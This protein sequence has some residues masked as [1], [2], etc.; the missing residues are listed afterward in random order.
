MNVSGRFRGFLERLLSTR[1]SEAAHDVATDSELLRRFAERDDQ[2]AFELLVW[3]HGMMVLGLCE[4]QIRDK[5]LAEDAFQAIFL[6]LAKKA[7]AIRGGNVAGWLYHVARRVAARATRSRLQLHELPDISVEQPESS[8]EREDAFYLLDVE[9]ARLPERLRRPVL[10]C[11][12]SGRSTEDAAR[13]LGCP[14]GTILSR[15]SC[16]RKLLAER[17]SRRGV[18]LPAVLPVVAYELNGQL[19]SATVTAA[20]RFAVGGSPLDPVSLLAQGVILNMAYNKTLAV[21]GAL[22]AGMGLIGSIGW[23]SAWS[24]SDGQ[25]NDLPT[26]QVETKQQNQNVQ[27]GDLQLNADRHGLTQ[28]IAAQNREKTNY[29]EKLKL[30]T[31]I[32]NAINPNPDDSP[33]RKLQRDR[34]RDRANYLGQIEIRIASKTNSAADL[35]E[36]PKVVGALTDNLLELLQKTEDKIKCYEFR[37]SWLKRMKDLIDMRNMAGDDLTLDIVDAARIDAEIELLKFKAQIETQNSD[38]WQ[39]K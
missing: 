14:R 11:Y 22:V 32:R 25:S 2:E 30:D 19:V 37:I 26:V 4:R 33:L 28:Q 31:V 5:H 15:L 24:G 10:L 16:A 13:E 7:R 1:Q 39:K 17:L 21:L 6:V 35:F 29:I 34:C 3:R 8:I 36:G 18:T 38:R 12:L 27:A 23:A 20:L 9:V